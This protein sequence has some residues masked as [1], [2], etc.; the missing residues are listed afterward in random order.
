MRWIV[1]MEDPEQR[2]VWAER[3]RSCRSSGL[4]AVAWCA[5][6][7]VKIDQYKYYLQQQRK[8]EKPAAQSA[9]PSTQWLSLEVNASSPLETRNQQKTLLVKVGNATI[10]VSPGFDPELLTDAV[11]ALSSLC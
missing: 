10:E 3:I 1:D 2:N 8:V 11:R 6:N 4:T 9:A 5:A 7:D